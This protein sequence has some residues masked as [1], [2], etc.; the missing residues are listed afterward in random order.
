MKIIK[1]A[2]RG[3]FHQINIKK[4]NCKFLNAFENQISF[5][6]GVQNA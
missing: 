3:K 4:Y 1:T 6:S 5:K 2:K